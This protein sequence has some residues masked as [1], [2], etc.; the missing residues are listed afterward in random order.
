MGA[1][2]NI[3]NNVSYQNNTVMHEVYIFVY[4]G[5][6]NPCSDCSW[7]RRSKN[8]EIFVGERCQCISGEYIMQYN[9]IEI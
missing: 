9:I 7:I 8:I 6:R 3:G 4:T 5:Q 2:P 1:N